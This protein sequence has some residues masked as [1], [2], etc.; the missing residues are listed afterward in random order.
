M[1]FE[2]FEIYPTFKSYL[3]LL[4]LILSQKVTVAAADIILNL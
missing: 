1:I 3:L 4:L 2:L